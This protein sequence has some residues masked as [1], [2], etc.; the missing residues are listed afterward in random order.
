MGGNALAHL[1]VRRLSKEEYSK[2]TKELS[3]II[4]DHFKDHFYPLQFPDKLSFG[5]IDVLVTGKL[6]DF[7]LD[8]KVLLF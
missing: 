3:I 4:K 1:G 8:C 6:K 5:D 2:Y 7:F